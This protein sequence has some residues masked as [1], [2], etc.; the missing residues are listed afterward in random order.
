LPRNQERLPDKFGG[1]TVEE[2]TGYERHR[3][4]INLGYGVATVAGLCLLILVF[5]ASKLAVDGHFSTIG[6]LLTAMGPYLLPILGGI[7][8]F[9]FGRRT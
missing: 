4:Q 8:G 7:V 9:A 6:P 2:Q 3:L 1:L 5:A